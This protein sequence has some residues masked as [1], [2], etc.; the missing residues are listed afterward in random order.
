MPTRQLLMSTVLGVALAASP[1][2]SPAAPGGTPGAPGLALK[3]AGEQ[4]DDVKT[5]L[6][7]IQ[8]DIKELQKSI[9]ALADAVNGTKDGAVGVDAGLLARVKALE[10]SFGTIDATLK[11]IE[12]K[13]PEQKSTSGF[14]PTTPTPM[15]SA[16]AYVRII[17]EYP[18]DMSL[19]INGKSHRLR[20]GETKTVDVTAGSYT[21]ELLHAGAQQPT[22]SL[23]KEGETVT[24]RIR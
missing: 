15:P 20:A 12:A 9:K 22:T 5:Q 18:T 2:T 6:E 10:S 1:A 7:Q 11:R 13:L 23:V 3:G 4:K 14:G 21:Y 16:R 19:L 24:L 8:K 17:N